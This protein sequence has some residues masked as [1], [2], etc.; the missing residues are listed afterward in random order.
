[1]D[2]II[3]DND[4]YPP[5]EERIVSDDPS[6]YSLQFSVKHVRNQFDVNGISAKVSNGAGL[7]MCN[8]PYF[9]A[10]HYNLS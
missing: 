1:M 10:L 6:A 7:Y 9:K 4:K 3:T 5:D 2:I 8:M